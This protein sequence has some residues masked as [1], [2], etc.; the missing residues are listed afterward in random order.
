LF[1]D[2]PLTLL[3]H[4]RIKQQDL[5]RGTGLT[6][7]YCRAAYTPSEAMDVLEDFTARGLA[8]VAK[9]NGGSGG[10]GVELVP[11]GLPHP[12]RA[13]RLEVMLE[14]ADRKYGGGAA[15]TAWP[16]RFFEFTPSTGYRLADGEHLWDLRLMC[17]IR[18]GEVSVRP[19]DL[20]LCPA[21]FDPSDPRRDS[22]VCNTTGRP[23]TVEFMRC[24]LASRPDAGGPEFEAVGMTRDGLSRLLRAA[25]EWCGRAMAEIPSHEG[26]RGGLADPVRERLRV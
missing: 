23:P 17:L 11:P 22:I 15:E 5:C 26:G 14:S 25:A 3:S 13:E 19:V 12:R 7:Q 9:I 1:H 4:D 8:A 20:R 16:L 2:G 18:P 24:P 10:C 6:P 21:P